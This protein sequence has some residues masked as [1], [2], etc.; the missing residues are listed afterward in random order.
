MKVSRIKRALILALLSFAVLH[1]MIFWHFHDFIFRGYGDFASFYT[2]GKIVQQGASARLY[3]RGLQW[4]VQQEFAPSVKIRSAPLPY[5]RPPFEALLFLPFAYLRYPAA[6]IAWTAANIALLFAIPFLL[7]NEIAAD[8]GLLLRP[9][10]QGFLYLGFCPVALDLLQGQDAILLLLLL[11]LVFTS[12]RRRSDLKAGVYLGLGLFKFHLVIPLLLL[13]LLQRRLRAALGF[14][15]SA[16]GLLLVSIALVGRPAFFSYPKYLWALNQAPEHIGI[17]SSVMPNIRGLLTPFIGSQRVPPPVL[18]ALLGVWAL[19]VVW[20]ARIWRN[21]TDSDAE[22]VGFSFCIVIT[23][24]TS[25]YT[26]G[27]D[28]TLLILPLLLTAGIFAR[29]A[30]IPGWERRL[31][32][33]SAALLLCSPLY[34]LLLSVHKFFSMGLVLVALTLSLGTPLQRNTAQDSLP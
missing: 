16:S 13:L 12:L 10:F 6:F 1:G 34:W 19:G 20:M 22:R 8:S 3:D 33:A 18:G 17:N 25:Y 15:C 29:D 27:H 26:V 4:Q 9:G 14:C 24:V 30:S 28:L 31:F 5:I 32:G 2:A 11:T 23:L 21:G 7:A